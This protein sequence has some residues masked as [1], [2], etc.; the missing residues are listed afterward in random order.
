MHTYPKEN[1][2]RLPEMIAA[3]TAMNPWARERLLSLGKTLAIQWPCSIGAKIL[4]M[5]SHSQVKKPADLVNNHVNQPALVLVRK[6]VDRE[7]A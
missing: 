6:P 1:M 7:Q 4:P 2:N 5:I 3:Y